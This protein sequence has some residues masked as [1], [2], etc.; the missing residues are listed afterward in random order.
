ME[1]NVTVRVD[2]EILHRARLRALGENRSLNSLFDEWLR[3]Y[4]GLAASG[5][6]YRELM[7]RLGRVRPGRKFSREEANER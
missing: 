4:A 2:K 1:Q 7:G 5:E 3:R 6:E